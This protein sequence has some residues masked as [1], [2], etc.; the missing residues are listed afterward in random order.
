MKKQNARQSQSQTLNGMTQSQG[1]DNGN[2]SFSDYKTE[3]FFDEM[4]ASEM[5]VRAGYA[6]FQQPG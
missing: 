3:D 1:Q 2:F 5:Q 4:F 6:P